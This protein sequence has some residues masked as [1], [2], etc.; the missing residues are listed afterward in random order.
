MV[1]DQRAPSWKLVARRP[2]KVCVPLAGVI[3]LGACAT[4][5]SGTFQT[6]FVE[7]PH[8]TCAACRLSDSEQG[9]WYLPS[10]P[11]SVTVRKGYGPLHIV[12]EKDGYE[13]TIVSVDEEFAPAT[14]GNIVLGGAIGIF[15]DA[16][17]SAAQRYPDKVVVWMKPLRLASPEEGTAWEAAKRAYEQSSAV[18]PGKPA[19]T[20]PHQ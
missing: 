16:A 3:G 7:T 18:A 5:V 15:V 2:S 14:L 17:S 20:G 11:G 19:S 9:I 10:T 13:T 4:I 1:G 6:F 12:C 8:L